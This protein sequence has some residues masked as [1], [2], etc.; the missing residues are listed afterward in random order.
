M[1]AASWVRVS[2]EAGRPRKCSAAAATFAGAS[3]PRKTI[4]RIGCWLPALRTSV[5]GALLFG[6][7][8]VGGGGRLTGFSVMGL[9]V[10]CGCAGMPANTARTMGTLLLRAA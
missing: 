2:R 9:G 6:A 1:A 7:D 8:T 4:V 10:T 5:R 3:T